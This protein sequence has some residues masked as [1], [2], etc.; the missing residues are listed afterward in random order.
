MLL[1]GG[2]QP[3]TAEAFEKRLIAL[4]GPDAV[5]V[6]VPAAWDGLPARFPS[7]GPEPANI[8]ELRKSFESKGARHVVILHTR[9]R[10]TANSEEFVKPLKTATAVFFTGGRSRV[11]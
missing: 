5:I 2:I 3:E 4:A 11:L 8:V 7:S 10:A 1:G 6:M 9:D